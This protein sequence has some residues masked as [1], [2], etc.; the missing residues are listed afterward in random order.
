MRRKAS[1][2]FRRYP[3]S[4]LNLSPNPA[5]CLFERL[6]GSPDF[7]VAH[8]LLERVDGHPRVGQLGLELRYARGGFVALHA[9]RPPRRHCSAPG[10]RRPRLHDLAGRD[11][12]PAR[13]VARPHAPAEQRD[14]LAPRR[15][16]GSACAWGGRRA[17]APSSR[18]RRA[19][20]APPRAAT[21]AGSSCTGC[22]GSGRTTS[23]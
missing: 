5:F 8:H 19:R 12:Q 14:G 4:R 3:Q 10:G 9:D 22:R 18:E 2:S 23:P 17:R 11:P 1:T 16:G 21:S 7:G 6:A 20:R 13:H 15:L